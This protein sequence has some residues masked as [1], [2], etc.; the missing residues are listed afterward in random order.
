MSEQRTMLVFG[1]PV[2]AYCGN[3]HNYSAEMCKDLHNKAQQASDLVVDHGSS[4]RW[5]EADEVLK[6][7]DEQVAA[8]EKR[9]RAA[10]RAK[11]REA[12]TAWIK[13][14]GRYDAYEIPET[15]VDSFFEFAA[16]FNKEG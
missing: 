5:L 6:M 15:V 16:I 10:E 11:L 12:M 4:R 1:Y 7:L 14:S 2:C 3:Q 13:D 9:I 8:E